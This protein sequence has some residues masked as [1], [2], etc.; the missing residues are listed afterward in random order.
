MSLQK[1][2]RVEDMP[3]PPRVTDVPLDVRIAAA[4]E[5]AQAAGRLELPRG[6]QRFRSLEE[7][8]AARTQHNRQ[9]TQARRK[10]RRG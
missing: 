6:V 2:R 5:R 4:W 10:S 9:R 8:Q 7:A 1:F 3:R